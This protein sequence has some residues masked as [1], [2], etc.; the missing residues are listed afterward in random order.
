MARHIMIRYGQ[1]HYGNYISGLHGQALWTRN[2]RIRPL[3]SIF[4]HHGQNYPRVQLSGG[5][6]NN[7]PIINFI[8][9]PLPHYQ[10]GK[11]R[12]VH[13]PEIIHFLGL[14]V[15]DPHLFPAGFGSSSFQRI[16]S[17]S[18]TKFQGWHLMLNS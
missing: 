14:N 11:E 10:H 18:S 7:L 8:I 9:P 1:T 16:V 2:G 12:G 13:A 5:Q 15:S 6:K 3:E 4:G 17:G